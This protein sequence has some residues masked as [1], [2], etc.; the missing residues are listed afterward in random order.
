M[1]ENAEFLQRDALKFKLDYGTA[2]VTIFIVQVAA[3]TL[4]SKDIL[5]YYYE[6]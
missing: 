5:D 1:R 3:G 4:Y 6:R 2:G